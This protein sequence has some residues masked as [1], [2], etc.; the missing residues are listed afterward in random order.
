M[1]LINWLKLKGFY[2]K[3][4]HYNEVSPH[5]NLIGDEHLWTFRSSDLSLGTGR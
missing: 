1:A 4:S 3:T 5:P 2:L